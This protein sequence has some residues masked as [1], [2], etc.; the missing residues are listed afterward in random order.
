MTDHVLRCYKQAVVF[1]NY[2]QFVLA[3]KLQHNYQARCHLQK[4]QAYLK[5]YQPQGKKSEA[6]CS[7]EQF[8]H[9]WTLKQA[10]CKQFYTINNQIQPYSRPKKD[11]KPPVK[12]DL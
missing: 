8:S 7:V 3:T 4:T 12:L 2:Y 5:P 1:S 10:D 6:E 11:I 9:M